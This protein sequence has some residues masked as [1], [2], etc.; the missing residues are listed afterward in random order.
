VY[1]SGDRYRLRRLKHVGEENYII[2]RILSVGFLGVLRKSSYSLLHVYGTHKV[3]QAY[4]CTSLENE[5]YI[6]IYIHTHMLT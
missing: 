4:S 6:N 1:C 2:K 5:I 3:F